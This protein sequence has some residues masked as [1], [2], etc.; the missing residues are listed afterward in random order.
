MSTNITSTS[1]SNN[2]N[3]PLALQGL[4]EFIG[5]FLFIAVVLT[6]GKAIPIA[7]ALAAVI[8]FGSNTSKTSF[9]PAIS[10][11]QYGLGDLNK[12]EFMVYIVAELVAGLAALYWYLHTKKDSDSM[13]SMNSSNS[14]HSNHTM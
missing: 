14:F 9:N 13:N 11:A 10:V 4:T 7:I 2:T 8:Y 6:K 5:T 1:N 3:P 12:S